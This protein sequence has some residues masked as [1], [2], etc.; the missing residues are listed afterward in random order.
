[1]TASKPTLPKPYTLRWEI[2]AALFVKLI[3]LTGLWFMIFH[4]LQQPAEKPDIATHF[5]LPASPN[6]DHST[7]SSNIK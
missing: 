5:A 7:F 2:T 4:W 3:L 1:M 6:A